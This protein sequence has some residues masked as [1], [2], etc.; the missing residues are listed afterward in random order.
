MGTLPYKV[1]P[2][3]VVIISS[4]ILGFVNSLMYNLL[5]TTRNWVQYCVF[6]GNY[7]QSEG[8]GTK[9]KPGRWA[10]L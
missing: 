7:V 9:D 4:I 10:M 5:V 2:S 3:L 1:S 8:A 6:F